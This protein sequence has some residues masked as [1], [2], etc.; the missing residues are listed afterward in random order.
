MRPGHQDDMRAADYVLGLMNPAELVR[1]EQELR[2]N[3]GLSR[4]VD[5]W[6]ERVARLRDET[7]PT[8]HAEMRKRI[9]AGLSQRYAAPQT[10]VAARERSR[11]FIGRSE[12]A[13][14]GILFGAMIGAIVV[15]LAI[16]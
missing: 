14:L 12:A 4:E 13:I 10:L 9:A 8:P 15:W 7:D 3:P 1:F 6:R 16:G 5:A 11:A 2:D